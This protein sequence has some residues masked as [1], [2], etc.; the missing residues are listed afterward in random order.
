MGDTIHYTLKSTGTILP[1]GA[2]TAIMGVVNCTPDSFSDGGQF[3]SAQAASDR[4]LQMVDEGADI[5]D[6]GGEST[7]PGSDP[8]SEEEEL[9]R[10]L[11]VIEILRRECT[12]WIS[13]DT[14]KANVARPA[15]DAGANIINDISGLRFDPDMPKVA[16]ESKVPVVVMHILGEPKNM[17][18]NPVYK[19]VVKDIY[20]YFSER[21]TTLTQ[22]GISRE[23]IILD[24]GIG[25]GKTTEHNVILINN[26][27]VFAKLQRPLLVGPSRKSF[28]GTLLNV[29]VHDR[30]EGT[31]A[32]VALAITRGA[33]I[34]R[35]HDVK[36]MVRVA[37]VTDA[38]LRSPIPE[39][40]GKR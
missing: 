4:A 12:V 8:V 5:I 18:L 2:R 22:C 16:A 35:V 21:I 29:E 23:N 34:V 40:T 20:S 9:N 30:L 28:I 37:K 32:A 3:T 1:L 27:H 24:P 19:D 6:I 14:C 15:L 36:E 25:F 10:V 33:H 39:Y 13:I 38:I 7:R 11:P 26:L 17:Q 31:A